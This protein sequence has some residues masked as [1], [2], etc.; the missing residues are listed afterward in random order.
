M[1]RWAL[2]ELPRS[3][4]ARTGRPAA[5]GARLEAP[6]PQQGARPEPLRRRRATRPET[7]TGW[8]ASASGGNVTDGC[9]DATLGADGSPVGRPSV[10]RPTC[11]VQG[12]R[13]VRVRCLRKRARTSRS[14][15]T[16]TKSVSGVVSNSGGS[17][18]RRPRSTC[19]GRRWR[20]R[21]TQWRR[22]RDRSACDPR[23]VHP[24]P[25]LVETP[26]RDNPPNVRG[27]RRAGQRRRRSLPLRVRGGCP[28]MSRRVAA[29]AAGNAAGRGLVETR[30][31]EWVNSCRAGRERAP[32]QP[33]TP[34]RRVGEGRARG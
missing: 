23:G 17:R 2:Q 10:R 1:R 8:S 6:A 5:S 4:P 32:G 3:T 20:A 19:R 18:P 29:G 22:R 26:V 34:L 30:G 14:T 12:R 9:R 28:E 16:G 25:P 11:R 15:R 31:G 13:R 7:W 33:I 21:R 24:D 27:G